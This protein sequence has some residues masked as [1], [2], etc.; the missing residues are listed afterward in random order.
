[1]GRRGRSRKAGRRTPSGQLSRA[2]HFQAEPLNPYAI[3]QRLRLI[4]PPIFKQIQLIA[5]VP[6]KARTR[7]EH[8]ILLVN[9]SRARNPNLGYPV[10]I[11]FERGLF[12][13]TDPSGETHDG[14]ELLQAADIYAG[15]HRQVWGR[16]TDDIEAAL[17]DR[18]GPGA[19]DL[20][21][22]VGRVNAPAPPA[23]HFRQLVAGTAAPVGD[24]DPEEYQRK[25]LRLADRYGAA[26]ALLNKTG[27][28]VLL[29]VENVVIEGITPAFLR[30]GHTPTAGSVQDREAF[31]AGL[32]ALAEHFGLFDPKARNRAQR[33]D[34]WQAPVSVI[35]SETS[36]AD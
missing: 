18:Y 24:P 23:T 12:R 16:L 33:V 10:G 13:F 27:L 25:R 19:F 11:A 14:R 32:K 29:V 7:E 17:D 22:E 6:E 15:L 4:D 36:A 5:R 26:R 20:L 34:S 30:P 2:D 3:S 9:A 1:M 8:D 35:E 31:V 21:L 28:R